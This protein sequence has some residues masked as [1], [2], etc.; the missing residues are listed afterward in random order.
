M[1]ERRRWSTGTVIAH[2]IA[3][4]VAIIV[5]VIFYGFMVYQTLPEENEVQENLVS[6]VV[7]ELF[8]ESGPASDSDVPRIVLS[9][10]AF[11][12][13]QRMEGVIRDQK[14]VQIQANYRMGDGRRV[15]TVTAWPQGYLEGFLG[16]DWVPQQVAGFSIGSLPATFYQGDGGSMIVAREEPYIYII[17]VLSDDPDGQTV[18]SL[19]VL[20]SIEGRTVEKANE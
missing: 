2:L 11:I 14:C 10:I 12:D 9:D 17:R 6:M 4:A 18:Y 13:E 1:R 7:S 5:A 19:G 8:T 15:Q 20:A 3:L 16:T